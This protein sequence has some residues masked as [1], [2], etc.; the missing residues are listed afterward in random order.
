MCSLLSWNYAKIGESGH[1]GGH[2]YRHR[3]HSHISKI[4]SVAKGRYRVSLSEP[5][6]SVSASR[7]IRN[8]ITFRFQLISFINRIISGYDDRPNGLNSIAQLQ[9]QR[10]SPMWISWPKTISQ[11]LRIRILL[12]ISQLNYLM[13]PNGLNCLRIPG[14]GEYSYMR[15]IPSKQLILTQIF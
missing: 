12:Q 1:S 8:R 11:T 10:L 4:N 13:L 9:A 14:Q 3:G 7:K 2:R 6:N 5:Q 15:W